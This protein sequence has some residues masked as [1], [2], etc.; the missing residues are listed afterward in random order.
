MQ[1]REE[2]LAY[3]VMENGTDELK[4]LVGVAH[5]VTVSQEELMAI[6]LGGLGLLVQDDATL[7]LQ[8]V[9][10]PDVMVARKV[11]HLDTHIRQFR[12]LTQEAGK[13]LRYHIFIFVPEVEHIAQQ[14]DSRSLLLDAVKETYQAALLRALVGHCQRAQVGVG[15]EIDVLHFFTIHCSLFT[16]RTP[17]RRVLLHSSCFDPRQAQRRG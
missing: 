17:V 3:L 13:T 14:V 15:K 6:D 5:A 7:L 16:S 9:V 12:Q 11:V 4:R 1:T 2:P 8:I 10:G